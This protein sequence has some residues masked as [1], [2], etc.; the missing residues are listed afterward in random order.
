M[1]T[2]WERIREEREKQLN[3]PNTIKKKPKQK[4]KNDRHYTTTK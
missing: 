2:Y 1:K 4:R 3:K